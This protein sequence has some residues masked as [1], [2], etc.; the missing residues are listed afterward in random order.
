[1][2][3]NPVQPLPTQPDAWRA[4]IEFAEEAQRAGARVYPQSATQQLQVFFALS[5]TFLFD[6]MPAFRDALTLPTAERARTLGPGLGTRRDARRSGPTQP[7]ATSCSAGPTSRSRVLIT[8]PSGSGF[9]FPSCARCSARA[10]TSTPSSTRRSP[11]TSTR[12]SRSPGSGGPA[13]RAAN[14]ATAAIVAHP[15]TLPGSSDAGAHLSSY[16]GV[17]YTTRL[18]TEYVPD[19]LPL[20]S[21][22]RG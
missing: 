9:A 17:D 1:M 21:P 10:T 22:S 5:D 18:L 11:K 7:A 13:L 4:G 2:N 20:E 15:L 19:A 3:I 12:C 6:E 8:I 16:C 14:P